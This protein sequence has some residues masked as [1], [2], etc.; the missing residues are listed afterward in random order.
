M[1]NGFPFLATRLGGFVYYAACILIAIILM[2]LAAIS[3]LNSVIWLLYLIFSS[4]ALIVGIFVLI[5]A[6]RT[7]TKTYTLPDE[8]PLRARREGLGLILFL[9]GLWAT[10]WLIFPLP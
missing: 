1:K 3:R 4:L 2:V 6:R 8:L 9:V 10:V 7:N 5:A